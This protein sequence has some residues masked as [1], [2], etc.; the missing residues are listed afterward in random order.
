MQRRRGRKCNPG[1]KCHQVLVTTWKRQ[2]KRAGLEYCN[3]VSERLLLL[4]TFW[5]LSVSSSKVSQ[6]RWLLQCWMSKC[7]NEWENESIH[8]STH[9]FWSILCTQ[10]CAQNTKM[11]NAFPS[12]KSIQPVGEGGHGKNLFFSNVASVLSWRNTHG[13]LWARTHGSLLPQGS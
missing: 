4:G 9:H 1:R 2:A 8:L 12:L 6:R 13:T 5:S 11:W 10:Q 7:I 3:A